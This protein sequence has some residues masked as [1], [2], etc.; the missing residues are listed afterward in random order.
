MPEINPNNMTPEEINDHI[1]GHPGGKG[2]A[3]YCGH[4][5]PYGPATGQE[6]SRAHDP[7]PND[8]SADKPAMP[9]V[10]PRPHHNNDQDPEHGPGMK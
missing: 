6:D 5:I 2:P 9:P 7:N 4:T 3:T 1:N 8:G 10:K